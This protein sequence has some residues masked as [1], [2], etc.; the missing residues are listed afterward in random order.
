[1]RTVESDQSQKVSCSFFCDC[2]TWAMPYAFLLA[3][4]SISVILAIAD[5][6]RVSQCRLSFQ[7]FSMHNI[8]FCRNITLILETQ[9][10]FLLYK[11]EHMEIIS[12]EN[13]RLCQWLSTQHQS[14][15]F[16]QSPYPKFLW[17][18]DICTNSSQ[19][20][21]HSLHPT[22]A[23]S[24]ACPLEA[25]QIYTIAKHHFLETGCFSLSCGWYPT[26]LVQGAAFTQLN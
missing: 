26:V 9:L 2:K 16:S 21:P 25:A 17:V 11:P 19:H 1:M 5:H 14:I 15:F 8:Y 13:Q 4:M 6:G 10:F 23:Q 24:I 7:D 20:I 3:T 22:H 18:S 12:T